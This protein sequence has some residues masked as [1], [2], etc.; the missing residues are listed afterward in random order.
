MLDRVST[1]LG[2]MVFA[3]RSSKARSSAVIFTVTDAVRFPMIYR[4]SSGFIW[5]E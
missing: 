1:A 2:Q 5:Q 4:G 3:A